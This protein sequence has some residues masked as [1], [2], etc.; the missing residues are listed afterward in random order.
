MMLQLLLIGMLNISACFQANNSL[1]SDSLKQ[2]L[3]KTESTDSIAIYEQKIALNEK[4]IQGLIKFRNEK[5][6]VAN[7]KAIV[8]RQ[9]EGIKKEQALFA[10]R[11]KSLKETPTPISQPKAEIVEAKKDTVTKAIAEPKKTINTPEKAISQP[12]KNFTPLYLKAEPGAKQIL[13]EENNVSYL[14]FVVDFDKYEVH[15]N[16]ADSTKHKRVFNNFGSLLNTVFKTE[17]AK[18]KMMMNGGIFK[19]AREATAMNEPLGL[20]V[21][22]GQEICP[23]NTA[24]PN[25]DNF[26]LKPN[27]VLYWNE[28][29][30]GIATTQEF[31]E[32][33]SKLKY[34][35]AVQ[36]GPM[37]LIDGKYHPAFKKG[38]PNLNIRNGVGVTPDGKRLIFAI[39]E[40]GTN[41]Y[42]FATL[43]K[44]FGCNNALY[45]DG[46]ISRVF[47]PEKGRKDLGGNFASII[48]VIEK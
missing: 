26:Y 14:V 16:W 30:A 5:T 17:K 25:S 15:I 34:S 10:E 31:E 43:F 37:L 11:I 45:L 2:Q 13:L 22:N 48:T 46:A 19:V 4:K 39:S 21:E 24:Y 44:H 32:K 40:E 8:D 27:G 23:L 3:Q 38:S 20:Y 28:K 36:S 12:E 41:F 9:V 29:S 35:N 18:V 47:M 7:D 33:Q 6:T 42:D 1:Q